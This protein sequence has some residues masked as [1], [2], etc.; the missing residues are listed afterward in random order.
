[1]IRVLLSVHGGW[2]G[3]EENTEPGDILFSDTIFGRAKNSQ[4]RCVNE[5]IHTK[6]TSASISKKREHSERSAESGRAESGRFKQQSF[7]HTNA[8][9]YPIPFARSAFRASQARA[10]R[11]YEV[12]IAVSFERCETYFATHVFSCMLSRLR[13]AA[14]WIAGIQCLVLIR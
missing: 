12:R 1:M 10:E 3:V 8:Y 4:K 2:Y 5:H 6:K 11:R 14:P 7:N 9:S 13:L